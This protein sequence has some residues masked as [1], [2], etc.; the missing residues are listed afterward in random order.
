MSS[1][2]WDGRQYPYVYG[3]ELKIDPGLKV[4]MEAAEWIDP[5]TYEVIRHALWNINVEHGLTIMKISGSPICAYGHDFNPCLLDEKGDFVFF[6]PFLQYLSSATSSAVKWTLEYRSE[7][8]GIEED[9]IFLTNDPWIGATHQSDVTLIAPV[10]WEGELFCWVGNTLH[11]WDLGGTAPGGFN[12]MAPDVYWEAGCIPPI[13]IVERGRLRRDLEEEYIRRSRMPELV[14]LDLRAEIAGCHVARERIKQLLARYGAATVKGVMRK[15]QDDSEKAFVRRLETIPDGTWREVGWVEWAHPDDRHIYRN[16]LTLTKRGDRL[17]FSNEGTDPQAGTLNCTLV[18]WRGAIMAM[19]S[20]Q[21]LFDQM[22]VVEG[23]YRHVEFDVQPGTLTCALFPAAVSAAPALTL[24]QT[25]ALSG[26]VISKMLA[27]SNDPELRTEVQSCMGAPMYPIVAL[28]GVNQRGAPYVSFLLD[29][30]GAALAGLSWRDGVDTGGWPWDLQSTM[31]NVEE[32][33]WFYPILYLWRRELPDSGGAGKFRGG[34]AAELAFIPH[35]TERI[36]LFTATGHCAV[37]GPGLFGGFPTSTTRYTLVRGAHA[38]QLMSA[39]RMPDRADV[40]GGQMEH[41]P[42]KAF[43]IV[44]G[45][46]DVFMMAWASAGGYGDPLLRDP[47]RVAEDYREGRIT[48]EWARR[49]YGVLLDEVGAVIPRE[50]EHLRLQMRR[51]RIGTEPKPQTATDEPEARI[52]AEGLKLIEGWIRCRYCDHPLAPAAENY[53]LRCLQK[54]F[55][56]EEANPH[57]LDPKTYIEETIEWRHFYC[58]GCGALLET[59]LA[60]PS[61]APLWDIQIE[62]QKI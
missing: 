33:E 23:A 54:S 50:T 62:P 52:L 16:C 17:I 26:L 27:C 59:E 55:S 61:D 7:N 10:F 39:G 32:I 19:V 21:M 35:G 22:F 48:R 44:Q 53:K 41:L 5:I 37:P 43:N 38:R 40:L 3:R 42:P 31:P 8:P 4:H 29:P 28:S 58:P 24:L 49:A 56:L 25:I 15:L 34:N 9:D 13:K 2:K 18:A 14:A 46:E 57:I 45:P 1:V 11:Q 12:P 60:R 20:A 51:Q 6:G 47:E 30:V 36:T